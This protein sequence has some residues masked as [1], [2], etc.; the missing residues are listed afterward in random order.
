MWTEDGPELTCECDAPTVALRNPADKTIWCIACSE[1]GT[2]L[3]ESF[4]GASVAV[5]EASDAGSII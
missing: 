5:K 4:D 1:C 2:T 3:K